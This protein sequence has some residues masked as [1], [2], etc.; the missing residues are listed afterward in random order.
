[1]SLADADPKL[2]EVVLAGLAKGWPKDRR[3][4]VTHGAEED[5]GLLLPRPAAGGRGHLL[6][7]PTARGGAGQGPDPHAL[8]RR[9]PRTAGRGGGRRLPAR[10]RGRRE[11]VRRRACRRRPATGPVPAG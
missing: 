10:R 5:L 11:E 2:A 9:P 7:L 1:A 8:R 4:E 3:A 6:R